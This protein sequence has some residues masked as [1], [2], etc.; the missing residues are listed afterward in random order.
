VN[1]AS[2]IPGDIS[3]LRLGTAPDSWGVWFPDDPNQIPWPRYLDEVAAAGYRWVELGPYGYLPTDPSQLLDQLGQRGLALSGG[4]VA[5][6]LHRGRAALEQAY[7]DCATEARTLTPLGAEYLILLPEG[8]TDLEGKVTGPTELTNAEWDEMTAGMSR[9]GAYCVEELGLKLVFHPHADSH[10]D[11]QEHIARFVENTDPTFVNLCLDTGHVAYCWGDNV[12]IIERYPERIQYVH[13]K[14]VDPAVRQRVRD[15]S[16]GF[17]TAVR[18]GGMV[19]PPLGDPPMEPLLAA[20]TALDRELFC[21]VE[22]DLYPCAADVPFP[23][24]L[25]TQQYL[26]GLGVGAGRPVEARA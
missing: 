4:A 17:A 24:A 3:A 7:T 10:V 12:E 9:L 11:T 6:G 23:I 16:L 19:E 18:L 1:H 21:I 15:E 5:A 20:L 25:R 8:F 22:Q 14:Q 13:L 26:A 2:R